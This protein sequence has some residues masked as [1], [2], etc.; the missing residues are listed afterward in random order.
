MARPIRHTDTDPGW[1]RRELRELRKQ[2]RELSA[3]KRLSAATIG[4]GGVTVTDNGAFTAQYPSGQESVRFGPAVTVDGRP[5]QAL[6]VRD[7]D[8]EVVFGANRTPVHPDFPGWPDGQRTVQVGDPDKG[9]D[10]FYLHVDG[11]TIT[12]DNIGTIAMSPKAGGA[13][14]IGDAPTTAAAANC[15]VS[16]VTGMLSRS[17]SSR[18]YKRDIADAE[19]DPAAVLQMRARTWRDKAEVAADESTGKRYVGFIAEELHDLGLGQFVDYDEDGPESI[20]YDRLSVAL[21]AAVKHLN[22]RVTALE[23][24]ES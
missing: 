10:L 20:Q 3:A 6:T 9:V 16:S 4:S 18:R 8:G 21:L 5:T 24:R 7:E 12:V 15:V 13:V 14:Q 23:A 1:I 17:T 2:V 22:E 19:V 11:T